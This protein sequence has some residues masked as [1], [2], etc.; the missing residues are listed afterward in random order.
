MNVTE[1]VIVV[2]LFAAVSV[3]GFWAHRWRRSSDVSLEQ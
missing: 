1:F 3:L 2:V